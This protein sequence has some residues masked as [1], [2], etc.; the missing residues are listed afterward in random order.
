MF[1]L[2]MTYNYSQRTDKYCQ[3]SSVAQKTWVVFLQLNEITPFIDGSL[4]YGPGKAWTDAIREFKRGYLKV[5][6]PST[7]DNIKEQF[8]AD[9]DIRLPFAN[10]PPPAD[11]YLKP[12]SRF[13]SRFFE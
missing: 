12:V 11:H 13:Y 8:P 9:N 5:R 7:Y 6:D 10:P 1:G 4:F 3:N 2:K